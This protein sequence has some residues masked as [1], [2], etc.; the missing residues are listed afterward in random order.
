MAW[1]AVREKKGEK[2]MG[3]SKIV[4]MRPTEQAHSSDT[5][6][7][8]GKDLHGGM[9]LLEMDFLLG[10]VEDTKG[11]DENDVSMRRLNFLELLRREKQDQI[12][13]IALK[14]YALNVG[15]LYGKHIQCQAMKELAKRT[16]K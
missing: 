6:E 10:I 2:K 14:V 11:N 9:E 3:T 1:N 12:D 4:E 16:A 13:S 15:D 7:R 8:K 5:D